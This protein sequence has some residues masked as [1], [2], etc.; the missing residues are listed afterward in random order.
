MG[1]WKVQD[2]EHLIGDDV[3]DILR[4]ATTR[5]AR[6]YFEEFD[7]VPTRAEWQI[8]LRNGL[9]PIEDV[10]SG[11]QTWLTVEG[12]RPQEVQITLEQDPQ[13]TD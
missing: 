13:R 12:S 5:I 11:K 6:R 10:D 7:R 8:L 9:E 3:L 2:T 1:W 4:D